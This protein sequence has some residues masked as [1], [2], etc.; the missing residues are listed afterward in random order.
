MVVRDVFLEVTPSAEDVAAIDG[1]VDETADEGLPQE[2]PEP[3]MVLEAF[4]PEE[5]A[6]EAPSEALEEAPMGAAAPEPFDLADD[7][8]DIAVEEE[9]E[10]RDLDVEA[11]PV[12][13]TLGQLYLQQGHPELAQRIFRKVLAEEPGH[14]V[15]LAGLATIDRGTE[16][17]HE[18]VAADLLQGPE[19][20]AAS[21]LT[22]RKLLLLKNYLGRIKARA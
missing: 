10:L 3:A 15:A 4:E 12:T 18:L 16:E 5:P 20:A 6:F 8:T 2:E 22:E 11:Q 19:A 21:G 13:A 14:P 17:S 9:A 1:A 7:D